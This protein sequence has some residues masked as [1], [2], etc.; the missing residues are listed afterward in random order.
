M[1]SL[2]IHLP[3]VSAAPVLL[4]AVLVFAILYRHRR[5]AR[6]NP[7]GFPNP[8]GP[9]PLPLIGNLL[10]IP[11]TD[12]SSTYQDLAKQYG[13]LVYLST[14]GTS[15][16]LVSSFKTA[17]DLFERRSTNYSDRFQSPMSHD[18]MGWDFSFAHMVYGDRWKKHRR[19][20]HHQFQPSIAP[21]YYPIQT[22]EAH[23]LLRRFLRSPD[24]L[25]YNLRQN[26]AS[27]VMKVTYGIQ[28]ADTNDAYV[29]IAGKALEGA[30]MA[31]SPGAFL[32][33][34]IPFLKHVP[35]WVPR[36]SFKRRAREWRDAVTHMRNDP[37][38]TVVNEMKSGTAP[39]S[40][41][42]NLLSDMESK[43]NVTEEDA[44]LIK[45]CAA[46]VYAASAEST[47]ST[48]ST[49]VLAML[50]YPDIQARA[51]KE[52]DSVVGRDRLPEFSDRDS[53]PYLSAILKEVL[54]WNPVAPL[55]LPHVV[56]H[57]DVYNGY[58]IP[59]GTIVIGNAWGIFNDETI[60]PDPRR[61]NP[62][63]FMGE[64][65]KGLQHLSPMDPLSAAFG[66]GR[67][68]C[69]GRYMGESQVWISIASILSVFDI[70]PALDEMGRPI[71]VTPEFSKTGMICHPVPFKYA[72]K[73]RDNAARLLI[74][75]TELN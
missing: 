11:R 21:S 54:R 45:N 63:R 15:I 12:E 28:I 50:T 75:Q 18:L 65:D 7:K 39:P 46:L 22:R 49:F 17:G 16:L 2:A 6:G 72:M 42:S 67:R 71:H 41:V 62:D 58:Y 31:T 10:D 66:Y 26:A 48:L 14:M 37:F 24:T 35:E 27:L 19:V 64:G 25:D 38:N 47:V 13:D 40:F 33:D 56:S 57:D 44:N 43:G 29:A 51:Q 32:V 60:Y 30:A 5:N 74:E 34:F 59:A 20:F 3:E 69:P 9:K 70:K 61:F 36:A 53:L 52:L 55:G 8:P 68:A 1:E 4:T 73:P 23:G